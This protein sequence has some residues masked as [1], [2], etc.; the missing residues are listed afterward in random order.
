MVAVAPDSRA[1]GRDPHVDGLGKERAN[2]VG[3][4]GPGLLAYEDAE[5]RVVAGLACE[6]VEGAGHG[7]ELPPAR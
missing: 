2:L 1:L 5:E 6:L 3:Q 4:S 7:A